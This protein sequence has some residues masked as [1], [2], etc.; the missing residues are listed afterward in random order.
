MFSPQ[1]VVQSSSRFDPVRARCIEDLAEAMFE[2]HRM[3]GQKHDLQVDGSIIRLKRFTEAT[4]LP[5]PWDPSTHSAIVRIV[6]ILTLSILF[7]AEGFRQPNDVKC[8]IVYLR[9][10]R[11]QSRDVLPA[12]YVTMSLVRAMGIQV[13]LQLGDADQDIEEMAD[14]CDEL[15]NSD[16]PGKSLARPIVSLLN[17]LSSHPSG[18]SLPSEKLTNCLRKAIVQLA[19]DLDH[20]FLMLASLHLRRF[21][22]TFLEDDYKEGMAAL[23]KVMNFRDPGGRPSPHLGIASC[24][25]AL[26][27]MFHFHVYGKS[28]YLEQATY[29]FRAF[30]DGI[31]DTPEHPLRPL[32]I[33]IYSGLQTWRSYHANAEANIQD[34]WYST[35]G[36]IKPP[37][38]RDLIARL[39]ELEA[40][41]SLSALHDHD[42]AL[43]LPSIDRLTDIAD[44]EDGI[45]YCRQLNAF[46]PN[47]PHACATRSTLPYFFWRAFNCTDEMEYLNKAISAARVHS[48]N[49]TNGLLFHTY[50][51]GQ[52]II[53]LSTRLRILGRGP[54]HMEDLNELM[55]LYP[56]AAKY[57]SPYLDVRDQFSF[58]WAEIAHYFGHPSALTAYEMAMTSMQFYLTVTPTLDKQHSQLVVKNDYFK[59]LP[60]DC[61][62]YQMRIIGRPKQ[63]IET[64]ERGRVLLWSEM[65]GLRI[66]VDQ[67]PSA[68]RH[69]AEKFTAVSRDLET[70]TLSLDNVGGGNSVPKG[71]DAFGYAAIRQKGL[72]DERKELVLKIQALPGLDTFM[73]PHSYDTLCG[74]ASHGPMIIIN[75][76]KWG[77]DIVILL[78]NSSPSLITTS[79]DFYARANKLQDRLLKER[80]QPDGLESNKYNDALDFVL[81]ELYELVGRPVIERLNKLNV[82]LQSRVW[83]CPTSVF[84]SLPLHA[85]GPIPSD[86]GR[87]QY[88]LDLYISSYI[89]SLFSL[90]ES[91]K[92]GSQTFD[93]PSM[94]VVAQPDVTMVQALKEVRVVKAVNPRVTK[95]VAAAATPSAVLERIQDHRFVHIVCHGILEPGK[96]LD[97]GFELYK[98]QRLSLLDVVRS[99]LPNAEFAFLAACHTAELT[100]QSPADE[101]LHLAAAMQFCGFRS[102]VGTMWAMADTDGPALAGDFYKSVFSGRE[103]EG[104]HYYERTAEALRDAVVKLRR[105]RGVTLERWVNYVHFGAWLTIVG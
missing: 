36:F 54:Y 28:E 93:K 61:A 23:D 3:S 92:S 65:R 19:P 13:E 10:L 11:G 38:F 101:V 22:M 6:V 31:R 104:V 85:M 74:A 60:L 46:Y 94:L 55:Q 83:W 103:Q 77:S 90:I 5:R 84:C 34:A 12:R 50:S 76:S 102:V 35:P 78:R 72:L 24:M 51:V 21:L 71:M 95:L 33:R 16:V 67:I 49:T 27:G 100:D 2:R 30:L 68:D 79:G 32:F 59:W 91:R 73:K 52:L 8:C 37:S 43:D 25:E 98:K 87:P 81:K 29:R 63:A 53:Y 47:S 42:S 18:K 48:T 70:L 97:S 26:F 20:P 69:L 66:T 9:Y 96:P 45:E 86:W 58:Q 105:K 64:L 40:S 7:H 41:T 99:R 17:A 4:S 88:F 75:H 44:I 56:T 15:F 82:P 89:P 62:S 14:L 57:E 80:R 1:H 39:P